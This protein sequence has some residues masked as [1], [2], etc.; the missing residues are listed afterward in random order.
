MHLQTQ[1]YRIVVKKQEHLGAGYKA[2]I[3]WE[4]FLIASWID[5]GNNWSID[6]CT[7][8]RA[9]PLHCSETRVLIR[10]ITHCCSGNSN[11]DL[12]QR[13]LDL[14]DLEVKPRC[15]RSGLSWRPSRTATTCSR[16]V[17]ILRFTRKLYHRCQWIDCRTFARDTLYPGNTQK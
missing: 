3:P 11:L 15:I 6:I 9:T 16:M 12:A 5:C 7:F 10:R 17:R 2:H 8:T 14:L 1:F 4:S 13:V